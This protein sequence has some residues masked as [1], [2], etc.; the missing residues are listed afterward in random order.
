MKNLISII[1]KWI[2]AHRVISAAVVVVLCAGIVLCLTLCGRKQVPIVL[3]PGLVL[4]DEYWTVNDKGMPYYDREGYTN[5]YGIDVSEWVENID[6][7]KIRSAGMD[8]VIFRVGY[9]G[10]ET[11]KFVLDTALADY[12]KQAATAGL[13]IGAYFVSQA[14]NEQEAIE[15]AQYVIDHV[16]GYTLEMPIYIDLEEVYDKA[17]TDDLTKEDYTKIIQAFIDTVEEQGYEGGVYANEAWYQEKVDLT[18]LK[19]FDLWLAKYADK[20]GDSLAVNMWQFSSE[21]LI[22][23]SDMWV[24]LNVRVSQDLPD[25]KE[26]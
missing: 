18:K 11:G 3:G 20:P 22:S 24:D 16:K 14:V 25:N 15:E 5:V 26:Q 9:R 4:E 6:F 23:G 13:K 8:F 2:T 12:L 7:R 21:G 17:R 19:D 10:Y 1:R